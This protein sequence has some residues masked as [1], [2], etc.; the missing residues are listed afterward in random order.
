VNSLL[1]SD[2]AARMVQ[3]NMFDA[4]LPGLEDVLDRLIEG[5]FGATANGAYEAEV[6]RAVEGVVINRIQWLAAN[7]SMPAVRAISTAKLTSMQ[8]R[9]SEMNDSAHATVLAMNI[10][11]F[12][13]RPMEAIETPGAPDAPPGA[14]IG[15]PAMDWL[16]AVGIGQPAQ[17]W[18]DL[19][20]PLCTWDDRGR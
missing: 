20:G 16:T 13:H 17:E 7:A 6:K 3:Q 19:T 14:P 15:Q 10:E 5:S 11:R 12:L 9:L 8:A 2:R 4:A 1:T 18:L